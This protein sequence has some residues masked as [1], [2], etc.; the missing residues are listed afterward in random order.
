MATRRQFI[1]ALGA[2]GGFA[3]AYAAMRE[4]G[5][6]G[7]E[8]A[9]AGP[10]DLAA[11]SGTGVKVIILG[12]GVAGLC[13]AFE[14]AKAGYDCTILEARNRVGGRNWTIR[15]GDVLELTDGTRQ[16]CDFDE[17]LY[18]N[19]GPARIPTHHQATLGYCRQFGV[20][21]ETVAN[22]SKS[23]RL[24]SDAVFGGRPIPMRQAVYD[25][26]GEVSQLLSKAVRQGAL[27][28]DVTA[29]DK[30]KLVA[31]LRDFGG[32]NADSLYRGRTAAGFRT[33][34][35]AGTE[36]PTFNDPL[37]LSSLLDQRIWSGTLFDDD[38]DMQATMQQPV[39]GMDRIPMAFAS[40]L[41]PGVVKLG[42]EVQRIARQGQGVAITWLDKASGR[43]QVINGDY[44]I[45]TIP[46]TVLRS[47]PAQFSAPF[48]SAIATAEYGDAV[49]VAFESER[50]WEHEDQIYGGLSFTDRETSVVWYPSGGFH[51]P[52]GIILGCYNWDNIASHFAERPLAD[53]IEYAR[54][55]IDKMHPGKGA[56]LAKGF[57]IHWK[58]VPYNLGSWASFNESGPEPHYTQLSAP[59][60]PFYFAGEHLSHVGAWQQ[61]A[62]L[63]AQRVI[64]QLD[65]R[66]RQ[67]RV[68]QDARAH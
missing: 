23:A 14:L 16:V 48:R 36:E 45:C 33:Q 8:V 53:Q 1:Q 7:T 32:L 50:W 52:K 63:S 20:D 56:Q 25:L 29:E 66:H 21:I 60:G 6:T 51:R 39:G 61:G 41:G 49:K 67:G 18:F 40:R 30:A 17:G 46:L 12:A 13:S 38:I 10:P 26:R 24:Q 62:L 4:M 3:A 44:C 9:Y 28:Q 64:G 58:K 42:A 34:P 2:V 68:V 54:T 65:A 27:D 55:S 19:A 47:I 59:D 37:P 31:F 15:R 57:S 22:N 35:G 5:L 43:S 11:G